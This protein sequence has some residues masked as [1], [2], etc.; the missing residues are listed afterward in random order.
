MARARRRRPWKFAAL[1]ISCPSAQANLLE[2]SVAATS[3]SRTQ[4]IEG[5]RA[6]TP[7]EQLELEIL[8]HI[9]D[10]DKGQH[11]EPA[12]LSPLLARFGEDQALSACQS[13]RF[14]GF[15]DTDNPCL[16]ATTCSLRAGRL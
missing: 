15:I 2:V 13:L 3:V 11:R 8:E 9:Y 1:S 7:Q 14:G 10:N 16:A 12:A 4:V 6:V 5:N